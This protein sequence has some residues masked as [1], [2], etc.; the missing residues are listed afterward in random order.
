MINWSENFS[1]NNNEIDQ[2]HRKLIEIINHV[3]LVIKNHDYSMEELLNIVD[4]L[5]KY[6]R[7]HLSY[8]EI[9]MRTYSYPELL[10]HENQHNLLRIKMD[11]INIFNVDNSRKFYDDMLV[12]LVEWLSIHIMNSDKLLGTFLQ[13]K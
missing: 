1:V 2:Q 5:D 6:I 8:E 9:L 11:E 3:A 7:E 4:G 10:V 12:Y 13:E